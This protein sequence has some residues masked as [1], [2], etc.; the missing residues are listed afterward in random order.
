MMS[1]DDPIVICDGPAGSFSVLHANAAF[2]ALAGRPVDD[3]CGGSVLPVL[4]DLGAARDLLESGLAGARPISLGTKGQPPR[5]LD[6]FPA[7]PGTAPA[8]WLIRLA[9]RGDPAF[10]DTLPLG[11]VL[12]DADD[13]LIWFNGTYRGVL[14]PNAHLLRLGAP[15][16]EIM[17][18]AY[19]AGHA[20][21]GAADIERL[22]T[23]RAARH[24][25]RETFEEALSGGRW[26]LTQELATAE[27]GTLGV[28]TDITARKRAANSL[29]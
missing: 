13:R 11:L 5:V 15:F 10:A 16:M 24:R 6:G 23:E 25:D 21:G 18:A 22:I 17:P 12:F 26:L 14:G 8:I 2:A 29:Q 4:A 19:R 27:G 1:D 3:L 20:A 7:P 9:A 28:R